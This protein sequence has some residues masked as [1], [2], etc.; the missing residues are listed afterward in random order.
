MGGAAFPAA[1]AII[2][3]FVLR[4]APCRTAEGNEQQHRNH[5]NGLGYG[6]TSPLR[7]Q[8]V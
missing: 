2:M 1:K 3:D 8:S 6:H 7:A 5:G 4:L